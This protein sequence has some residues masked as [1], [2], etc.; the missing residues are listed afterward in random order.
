MGEWGDRRAGGA[1]VGSVGAWNWSCVVSAVYGTCGAI[2]LGPTAGTVGSDLLIPWK[3]SE[4]IPGATDGG[5]VLSSLAGLRPH[6][7]SNPPLK[8]WAIFCRP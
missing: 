7:A 2:G 5:K 4:P 1:S 3:K 6:A 8:W